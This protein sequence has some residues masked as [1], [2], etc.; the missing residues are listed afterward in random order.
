MSRIFYPVAWMLDARHRVQ[1]GNAVRSDG[2][3]YGDSIV[4]LTALRRLQLPLEELVEICIAKGVEC[5]ALDEI[6]DLLNT[7]AACEAGLHSWIDET[8]DIAPDER[9]V[10]CGETYGEVAA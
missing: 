8:G 5:A 1:E 2:A 3:L 6:I 7:S 10:H 4:Y 9:C